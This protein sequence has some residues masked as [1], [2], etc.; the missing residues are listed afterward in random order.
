MKFFTLCLIGKTKPKQPPISPQSQ[1]KPLIAILLDTQAGS[2][3]AVFSC[4]P[5]R[6]PTGI[7]FLY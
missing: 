6:L 4:N 2:A 1:F 3:S 5:R 7:L